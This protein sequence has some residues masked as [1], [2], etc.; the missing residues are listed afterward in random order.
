[1]IARPLLAT[2]AAFWQVALANKLGDVTLHL[3]VWGSELI[4]WTKDRFPLKYA[5]KAGLKVSFDSMVP[6][7]TI[8]A[9]HDHVQAFPLHWFS[10]HGWADQE[11][12]DMKSLS[13]VLK[14]YHVKM[15]GALR[16]NKIL[17]HNNGVTGMRSTCVVGDN[18]LC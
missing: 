5:L 17:T 15:Q 9:Q 1:M 12:E 16:Y 8:F 18:P 14:G 10:Q 7:Q 11:G 6:I 4:L 13:Q 2:P 3:C